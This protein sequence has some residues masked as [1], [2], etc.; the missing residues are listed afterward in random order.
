LNLERNVLLEFSDTSLVREN[1]AAS[2]GPKREYA[3]P[4]TAGP[5]AFC[6]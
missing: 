2:K 1:T 3:L 4:V 5:F 6:I